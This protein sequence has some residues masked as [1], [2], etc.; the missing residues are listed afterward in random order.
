MY[1]DEN[2]IMLIL[3]SGSM[4][5]FLFDAENSS[6]NERNQKHPG[7]V[8][9][10]VQEPFTIEQDKSP[11]SWQRLSVYIMQ[12]SQTYTMINKSSIFT[13]KKILCIF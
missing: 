5:V 1:D 13:A 3:K 2:I 8:P 6:A 7:P 4:K 10:L 9:A 11:E 12:N